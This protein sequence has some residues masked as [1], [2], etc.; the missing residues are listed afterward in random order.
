MAEGKI[1]V[2]FEEKDSKVLIDAIKSL[3]RETKKLTGETNRNTKASKKLGNQQ[4]N[5]AKETDK[6][7]KSFFKLGGT[8]SV[9][10][11][12]LLLAA[13]AF[14][15]FQIM[16]DIGTRGVTLAANFEALETRLVSMTGSVSKASE[17]MK[18][19][20]DIAATTPFG[21][22]DIVEAGVQL[23]AF[24][25]DAQEMIKPVADLAAFMGTTATEAASALGRAFAGGAG[26]ADILR[27]R[28]ILQL[29]KDTQGIT[30]LSK[31]TLP[32]FR[33]ALQNALTDPTAGIA[34]ATTKLSK[35]TVGAFSNMK[36]ALDNL[37]AKQ[38]EVTGLKDAL[39]SLARTITDSANKMT[40]SL[41]EPF[42]LASSAD[43]IAESQRIMRLELT[44]FSKA[45]SDNKG[46]IDFLVQTAKALNQE[47]G[48]VKIG[49]TQDDSN[50]IDTL[51]NKIAILGSLLDGLGIDISSAS[52][53][54]DIMENIISKLNKTYAEG[55]SLTSAFVFG[56]KKENK[57]IENTIHS[58][59]FFNQEAE[60]LLNDFYTKRHE[61]QVGNQA[62]EQARLEQAAIDTIDN[63]T[64]LQQALLDIQ[65][66]FDDKTEKQEKR[67]KSRLLSNSAETMAQLLGL[68]QKNMKHVARL[69]AVAGLVD[70][71]SAA[72]SQ[73]ALV[74][75]TLPPPFPQIAYATAIAQGIAQAQQITKAAGTP[76]FEQGGLVGGKRHS[77]GGTIIEA[78]RGEFVMSRNAVSAIGV[79][80]LNKMNEGQG[81]TN[82]I[83]INING[84]MISPDFVENELAESIREAV[85]RGADFGIS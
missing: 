72:Q 78:E 7:N 69:Q 77:Q 63:E 1:R 67:A 17:M 83:S 38:A 2:K 28:G 81:G 58:Y 85:R 59:R 66:H 65:K 84:G 61:I 23:R 75:K 47:A 43:L 13:F 56:K 24:G 45:I 34:G 57:E 31:T 55:N 60:T 71:Y 8:L 79:E 15:Q 27:E 26:A 50:E 80:N 35:T 46:N 16:K 41:D 11:S 39:T 42:R 22:Q 52:E 62:I 44:E 18:E 5:T 37:L 12:K 6:S 14:K 3:N 82:N 36:D 21:V 19:F 20:R 25:V 30:D 29:I 74:S 49:F 48:E 9:L 51:N 40:K 70:A 53:R 64:A 10:R 73:F 76:I 33:E 54:Y 32:E 68:N 4:R